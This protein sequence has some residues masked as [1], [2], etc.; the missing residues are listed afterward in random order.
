MISVK[1][2]SKKYGSTTILK[3][4]N[5][6]LPRYGFVSIVGQS[7]CGKSTFLNCLSRLTN[8]R[9]TIVLEGQNIKDYD[10]DETY[11]L[12]NIGFV[13]QD[14]KLYEN[15]TVYRNVLL[16][17]E[18]STITSLKRKSRKIDDLLSAVGIGKLKNKI[19]KNL[20][21]GQKQR[22][23]IARALANDPKLILADEPT[24]ALDSKN[25]N[26]ILKL[27]LSIS[28][29]SLVIMVTHDTE[30]AFKYADRIIEMKSGMITNTIFTNNNDHDVFFPISKNP[31]G[32]KRSKIPFSFL[33]SHSIN[34]LK[35]KKWR[36]LLCNVV[37][38]LGLIGVGAAFTLTSSIEKNVKLSY[39]S[40]ID[41]NAISMSVKNA[42]QNSTRFYS[43]DTAKAEDICSRYSNYLSGDGV[44]YNNNFEAIF[45]DVDDLCL[46]DTTYRTRL[47]SF[48][49]RNINEFRW[50]D[51]GHPQI[52]PRSVETLEVDE[53]VLSMSMPDVEE[54]CWDLMIPRSV[55]SLSSYLEKNELFLYFDFANYSWGYSDQQIIKV[56]G[57]TFEKDPGIYHSNHKWNE[58]MFELQ[59]KLPSKT[60]QEAEDPP[61]MLYKT[62]FVN[63]H[64]NKESFIKEFLSSKED[65]SIILELANEQYYP[66]LYRDSIPSNRHR[67]LLFESANSK[68]FVYLLSEILKSNSHLSNPI[69][70]CNNAYSIYP[71]SFMSGF[72][73]FFYCSSSLNLLNDVLDSASTLNDESSLNSTLPTGVV[74]GYFAKTMQKSIKFKNIPKDILAG[75]IPKNDEEVVISSGLSKLLFGTTNCVGK[76]I[77]CAYTT[78]SKINSNKQTIK[79]FANSEFLVCGI[80][81]A[82]NP[83]IYQDPFWIITYFQ[84]HFG[85]S[86]FD[87]IVD[88][89]SF[90]IDDANESN[91]IVK[92]LSKSFPSFT[93]LNPMDSVT[94]SVNEICNWIKIALIIFSGVAVIISV[95]LLT[96]CNYLHITENAKDIA[97]SRC[98]GAPK[99]EGAKFVY[100]YSL[101]TC[102]ISYIFSIFEL[103]VVSIVINV[104]INNTLSLDGIF[105]I[106]PKSFLYMALLA[107]TIFFFSSFSLAKK[108][109]KLDPLNILKGNFS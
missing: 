37:M 55:N 82:T 95:L 27:L 103:I 8:Y 81:E 34:S 44:F 48:S 104:S 18:I 62:H 19:V 5:V 17:L 107:L 102:G 11:R 92:E 4:L 23:S 15:E 24:G 14:F 88:T 26:E 71:S 29:R 96:I 91:Q 85:I 70:G 1:N 68:S 56:K 6:D 90:E 84:T 73:N 69:F 7:G 105:T 28:K 63:I 108:V 101:I 30:L 65:A 98:I 46:L 35:Q 89:I 57:F 79:K 42:N 77:Q 67:F 106:D 66:L 97:L 60:F 93:F 36:S 41:S 53:V 49:A 58:Y 13:F 33:F 72:S 32:V 83:I 2:L 51:D 75:T 74:D 87:L 12:K 52:Y 59:M 22:V 64:E 16:P 80:T 45:K 54:L 38:S 61:W 3:N 109:S 100:C 43:A 21:G 31:I 47:S 25:A 20:S 39:A 78:E 76:T 94:V 86:A 10:S 99:K 50:L 40:I 9:G